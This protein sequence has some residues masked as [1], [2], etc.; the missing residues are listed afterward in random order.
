MNNEFL[1]ELNGLIDGE[2]F[3]VETDSRNVIT[4]LIKI[5]DSTDD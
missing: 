4:S 3:H 1:F 5:M 2:F